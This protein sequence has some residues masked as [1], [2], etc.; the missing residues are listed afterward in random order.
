MQIVRACKLTYL[1]W[2]NDIVDNWSRPIKIQKEMKKSRA[3]ACKWRALHFFFLTEKKVLIVR[4]SLW[5]NFSRFSCLI[6]ECKQGGT[7]KHSSWL[8]LLNNASTPH[9]CLLLLG[10]CRLFNPCPKS[11][12]AWLS[13][14]RLTSTERSW[15]LVIFCGEIRTIRQISKWQQK[16]DV[17]SSQILSWVYK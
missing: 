3:F 16:S 11:S 1:H 12:L 10:L 17:F 5:L 15:P 4:Q 9:Q 7:R 2:Y 8:P 14:K 13:P 6:I